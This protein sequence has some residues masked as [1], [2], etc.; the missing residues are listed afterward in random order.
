[1]LHQWVSLIMPLF[2]KMEETIMSDE[3]WMPPN[4][5]FDQESLLCS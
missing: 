4:L 3:G 5:A 2:F 1:M